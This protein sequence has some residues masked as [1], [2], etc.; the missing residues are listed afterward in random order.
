TIV[1]PPL[2][3]RMDILPFLFYLSGRPVKNVIKK[4]DVS[5]DVFR[6]CPVRTP[7]VPERDLISFSKNIKYFPGGKKSFFNAP[8]IARHFF[9]RRTQH[10]TPGCNQSHKMILI[11]RELILS[12]GKKS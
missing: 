7:P 11:H 1:S 2:F 3:E 10:Q 12:A 5:L 4:I 6:L 9:Y 8:G